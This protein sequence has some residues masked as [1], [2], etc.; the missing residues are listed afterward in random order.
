TTSTKHLFPRKREGDSLGLQGYSSELPVAAGALH[1][2]PTANRPMPL[3][4]RVAS[5]CLL[6]AKREVAQTITIDFA[7]K[8]ANSAPLVR[9]EWN[10]ADFLEVVDA[11]SVRLSKP[12]AE[13]A[14]L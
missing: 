3:L 1:R 8:C 2:H 12:W 6:S 7:I 9:R 4:C 5:S 11:K 10:S 13:C 14:K